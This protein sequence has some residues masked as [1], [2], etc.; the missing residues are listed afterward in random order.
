MGMSGGF[1]GMLQNET[2]GGSD[3]FC[4][5]K[6]GAAGSKPGATMTNQLTERLWGGPP[7]E[8]EIR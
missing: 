3:L 4:G 7:K 2:N 8:G 1:S 6:K 5:A